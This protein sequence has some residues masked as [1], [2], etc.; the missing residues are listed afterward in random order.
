MESAQR[1]GKAGAGAPHTITFSLLLLLLLLSTS[2]TGL[3]ASRADR[4]AH[5]MAAPSVGIYGRIGRVGGKNQVCK[6]VSL[7]HWTL[8]HDRP[9][10]FVSDLVAIRLRLSFRLVAEGNWMVLHIRSLHSHLQAVLHVTVE[11]SSSRTPML[12]VCDY[13]SPA[14]RSLRK[15]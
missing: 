1:W 10:S 8:L 9:E 11:H 6:W 15:S 12:G 4:T 7:V 3:T 2:R 13:A 5:S 14:Q